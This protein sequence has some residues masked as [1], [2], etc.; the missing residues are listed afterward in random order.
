[1]DRAPDVRTPS[2]LIARLRWVMVG[3][4]AVSALL[5]LI[6]QP[7]SFWHDPTTAIRGD[8]L[9]IHHPTNHT[10]EFFLGHG[11]AAFLAANVIYIALAFFIVSRLPRVVA[12]PAVFSMLFAHGYGAAN[13]LGVHFGLGV[14]PSPALWGTACG[15]ALSFAIL[16][17]AENPRGLVR[18]WRWIMIATLFV[19]FAFTLLGQPASYWHDP[20]MMHEGNRVTRLFLGRSW[21]HLLGMN[22]AFAIGEFALATF[23]PLPVA[24]VCAF[25]FIF[26]SFVGATN[27][28]FYEWRL[29]WPAVIGY[30]VVLSGLMVVP[31]LRDR[32][33]DGGLGEASLP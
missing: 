29:G 9:P 24:F 3:A 16:P 4:I 31:A 32:R 20:S 12:V 21:L 22:L 11:A 1:M 28:L 23:L 27:W 25:G 5:T 26:G 18:Y 30:C 14:G 7:K 2:P 8:G 10:F 17:T 13:W 15:I 33:S 6:C 19:D